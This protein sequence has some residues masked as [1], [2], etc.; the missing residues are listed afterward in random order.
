MCIA[1]PKIPDAPPPP[2]P[3]PPLPQQSAKLVDAPV[4]LKDAQRLAARL[5]TNSLVIPL[6]PNINVPQ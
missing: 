5:G 2:A 1:G 3:P 4:G 6:L